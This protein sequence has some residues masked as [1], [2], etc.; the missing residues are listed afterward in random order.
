MD[1]LSGL[2]ATCCGF[3]RTRGNQVPIPLVDCPNQQKTKRSIPEK[4][5][6]NIKFTKPNLTKRHIQVGGI[7]NQFQELARVHRV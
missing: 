2:V 6:R 5:D 4:A 3:A 7:A 1:F